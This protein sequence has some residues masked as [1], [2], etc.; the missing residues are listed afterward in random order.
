M[1]DKSPA[2]ADRLVWRTLGLFRYAQGLRQSA[3]FAAAGNVTL[4]PNLL[5]LL[6]RQTYVSRKR[7]DSSRETWGRV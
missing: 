7:A 3:L 4:A 6:L 2:Q 1:A 5:T